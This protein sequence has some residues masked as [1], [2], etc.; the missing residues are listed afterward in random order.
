MVS[1]VRIKQGV[2]HVNEVEI[3]VVD[4]SA[5]Q[6]DVAQIRFADFLGRFESCSM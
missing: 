1:L 4:P 3:N 5:A 2:P 6:V